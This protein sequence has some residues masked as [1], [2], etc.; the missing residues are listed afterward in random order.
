MI[1]LFIYQSHYGKCNARETEVHSAKH[2]FDVVMHV[3]LI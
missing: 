3:G 2:C 1:L